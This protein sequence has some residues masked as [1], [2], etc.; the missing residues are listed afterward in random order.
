MVCIKIGEISMSMCG[1][2]ENIERKIGSLENELQ[3][4]YE[5]LDHMQ[6]ETRAYIRPMTDEERH[7]SIERG[8]KR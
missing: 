7:R 4:L 5:M 6:E 8:E 3:E 2:I 1:E